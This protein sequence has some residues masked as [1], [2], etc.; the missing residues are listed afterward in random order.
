MGYIDIHSHILPGV[1]D[2]SQN[3]DESLEMLHRAADEGIRKMILTPHNKAEHKNV[4]V[5]GIRKRIHT[6]QTEVSRQK[7]PITLYPG[8]EIFYRDGVAE[9]LEEGSLCTLADTRYVLVEFQPLEEFGYIRSAIYELTSCGFTPILA[10]VERYACMASK[11]DNVL[12]AIDRGALIQINASTVTGNMGLKG[13]QTVKKMLKGHMV[14]FVSTDAHDCERRA[15]YLAECAQYICKK[16][17]DAY[18]AALLHDNASR[19][20]KGETV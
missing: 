13:K 17:G 18:A 8:N 1:D 9:M 15:P 19:L 14:H 7:I 12:Y 10:H 2:G 16:F 4:S 3:M 5:E 11:L 20:L 6:L